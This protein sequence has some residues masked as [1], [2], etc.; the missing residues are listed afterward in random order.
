MVK[1]SC[2]AGLVALFFRFSGMFILVNGSGWGGKDT[3]YQVW[4]PIYTDFGGDFGSRKK[5]FSWSV[6][7][8]FMSLHIS[9]ILYNTI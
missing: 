3:L 8:H 4:Y 9:V 6:S 5:C 1:V 2:F 7:F